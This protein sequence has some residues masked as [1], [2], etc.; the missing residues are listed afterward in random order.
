MLTYSSKVLIP[1]LSLAHAAARSSPSMTLFTQNIKLSTQAPAPQ[2][3]NPA[4]AAA[5][6]ELEKAKL[7]HNLK[8]MKNALLPPFARAEMFP[9]VNRELQ[10]T[11]PAPV[12]SI[13]YIS[14]TPA[15]YSTDITCV[16]HKPPRSVMQHQSELS[17]KAWKISFPAKEYWVNNLMGWTSTG[18]ALSRTGS[19]LQNFPSKEIAIA[20]AQKMGYKFEVVE[21]EFKKSLLGKKS[22]NHNFLNRHVE[23]RMKADPKK[24]AQVQFAHPERGNVAFVNLKHTPFGEKPS[25]V[26][27]QTH[28]DPSK[29]TYSLG[30]STWRSDKYEKRAELARKLGK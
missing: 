12:G 3:P 8:E 16:I 17:S 4:A 14:G 21:P 5:A 15:E 1:S 20:F 28:W 27:S 7:E 23:K 19:Q 30:T 9:Q 22:Y 26:V 2:A 6:A 18:D 11:R 10:S 29:P 24:V 13:A 25:K